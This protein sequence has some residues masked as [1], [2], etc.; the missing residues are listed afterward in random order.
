M[1]ELLFDLNV[2]TKTP[3]SSFFDYNL[4]VEVSNS[5]PKLEP[6]DSGLAISFGKTL[7]QLYGGKSVT[8]RTWTSEYAKKFIYA[9]WDT[10]RIKALDKDYR[11]GGKQIGWLRLTAE[12]YQ[13]S[14]LEIPAVDLDLEGFPELS[15]EKIIAQFFDNNPNQ[16][17]WVIRFEFTP[18]PQKICSS[19]GST[20][21]AELGQDSPTQALNC[22]E[23]AQTSSVKTTN[24]ATQSCSEDSRNQSDSA[25]SK[26]LTGERQNLPEKSTSLVPVPPVNPSQSKENDSEP[27]TSETVSQQS[28]TQSL[29][30]DQNLQLW[31]TSQESST[32]PTRQKLEEVTSGMWWASFPPSGSIVN[33]QLSAAPSLDRPGIENDYLLLRS[34]GALS[35]TGKG[36]PPGQTKLES[37]LKKLG[38][39]APGEVAN[40]EFLEDGFNLPLGWTSREETQ[41]AMELAQ[42]SALPV[43]MELT[44][45]TVQPSETPL[46]GESQPL[47]SVELNTLVNPATPNSELPTPLAQPARS[48]YSELPTPN[49][50]LPTPNSELPTPNSQAWLTLSEIHRD[51]GTQPRAFLDLKHVATLVEVLEDGGELDPVTVFY[52]G[53]SYWLADG[54]HRCKAHEDYGQ[55]EINCTII[56]GIRR[57][58]VL[59]SVGANAEHKAVKPRSRED[60]RRAVT[61]LL[62][63]PEWSMWSDREI[64]RQCKVGKDLVGVLR[65]KLTVGSDSEKT[66]N[67][68]LTVGSDSE[69]TD[70]R[71]YTT[72][73]GTTTKMRTGNIGQGE[74]KQESRDVDNS[75]PPNTASAVPLSTPNS[76]GVACASRI[77]QTPHSPPP[78]TNDYLIGFISNIEEMSV[79]QLEEAQRRIDK[80][81]NRQSE[82]DK[83]KDQVNAIT[84][85]RDEFQANV[86]AI[87]FERDVRFVG[88]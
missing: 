54:F 40:P 10:R 44:A 3:K 66:D 15:I 16:I 52:D 76:V 50:Q 79:E 23:E 69:K 48:A 59:Y 24:S 2:Y 42:A 11:Y 32:A 25:T 21:V 67:Q 27:T 4:D 58:A 85:E 34:P 73:H 36:R 62:Y 38:L 70:T 9:Y 82:V 51:G 33:G 84:N 60:K 65:K 29:N 19:N 43:E 88:C 71:T 81:L 12:P 1:N 72:K 6:K 87:T 8:R 74:T 35:S 5:T 78:S 45:I 18:F 26:P 57:D 31:K 75:L 77:L 17:V 22:G 63:D 28:L 46:T 56:Q 61:M 47:D 13:E 30:S 49:S 55:E 64:A 41:T 37:Q 53:E 80:R 86:V 39:I 14:L 20:Y 7:P 68:N 83:L